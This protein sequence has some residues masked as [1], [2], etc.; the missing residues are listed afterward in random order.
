MTT[1][2]HGRDWMSSALADAKLYE[3]MTMRSFWSKGF[4]MPSLLELIVQ[5]RI[6]DHRRQVEFLL[7]FLLPLLPQGGGH[8]QQDLPPSFGPSLGE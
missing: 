1:I 5:P 4:A 2:S 7:Q 3:Q 6:N 8:D